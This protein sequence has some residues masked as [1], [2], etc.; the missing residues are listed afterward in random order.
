MSIIHKINRFIAKCNESNY[1]KKIVGSCIILIVF[2][3]FLIVG[4]T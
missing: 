1:K 4:Y 2:I 3:I